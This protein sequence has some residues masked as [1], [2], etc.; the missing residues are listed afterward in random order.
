M[1]AQRNKN[2]ILNVNEK[3][4]LNHDYWKN[5]KPNL[6]KKICFVRVIAKIKDG[7]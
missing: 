1:I 6:F 4:K 5:K 3:L 2:T 7:K